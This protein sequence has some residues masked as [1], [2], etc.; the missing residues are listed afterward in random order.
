M[1]GITLTTDTS[2]QYD[3]WDTTAT[4]D[5]YYPWYPWNYPI[6]TWIICPHCKL[7]IESGDKYCRYCGKEVNEPKYC[8]QCG[9]KQ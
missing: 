1:S 7:G 8:P 5:C 4:T 2:N 9:K 6:P 3:V